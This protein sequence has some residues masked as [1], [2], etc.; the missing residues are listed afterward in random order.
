MA[1]EG[2]GDGDGSW[3]DVSFYLLECERILEVC[4]K[5]YERRR[6]LWIQERLAFIETNEEVDKLLVE[7]LEIGDD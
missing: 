1:I 2:R 5:S 3:R 4:E 6:R 7:L